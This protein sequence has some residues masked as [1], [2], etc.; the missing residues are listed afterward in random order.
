[1][2]EKQT[3]ADMR[4][5]LGDCLEVMQGLPSGSVDAEGRGR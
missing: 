4:L 5:I 3:T 2:S 1:M